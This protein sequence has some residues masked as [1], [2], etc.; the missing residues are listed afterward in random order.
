MLGFSL[1]GLASPLSTTTELSFIGSL[2]G[3]NPSI[4]IG[5][6]ISEK[7]VHD[8]IICKSNSVSRY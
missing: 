6:L 1:H 7:K 4:L 3:P 5:S 2:R 8:E